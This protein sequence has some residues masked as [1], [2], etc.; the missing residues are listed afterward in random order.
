MRTTRSAL[1]TVLP[2]CQPANFPNRAAWRSLF[3]VMDAHARWFGVTHCTLRCGYLGAAR[4]YVCTAAVCRTAT[5]RSFW[6]IVC[7]VQR[8]AVCLLLV[9]NAAA[10]GE[11][12]FCQLT[13][14]SRHN[15][16]MMATVSC[17]SDMYNDANAPVLPAS[18]LTLI[19][20]TAAGVTR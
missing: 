10:H 9:T 2:A 13:A 15:A 16:A 11:D 6:L 12:A 18:L 17:C 14:N 4:A 3:Y 1:Y 20:R 5:E 8:M 19:S 7:F